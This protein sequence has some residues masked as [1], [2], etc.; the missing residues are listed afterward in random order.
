MTWT[1]AN[2]SDR[3]NI[4]ALMEDLDDTINPPFSSFP[5][6]I[7]GSVD[8]TYQFGRIFISE[9][10]DQ[11]VGVSGYLKGMPKFKDGILTAEPESIAYV[12]YTVIRP[13]YRG[14]LMYDL[15]PVVG[16]QVIL[17]G[18]DS[19]KFKAHKHEKILN[20]FYR[21]LSEKSEEKINSQ[22]VPC[23]QYTASAQTWAKRI[24]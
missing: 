6:G 12:Y 22:D 14:K 4:I 21:Q 15:L 5:N 24:N 19:I 11:I 18:M 13:A 20:R 17:D 10:D 3:E 2:N 16:N 23:L 8:L 1:L 9:S 7:A